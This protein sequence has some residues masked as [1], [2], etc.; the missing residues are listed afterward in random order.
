MVSLFL[1]NLFFTIL[2]PGTVAVLVPY[3]LLSGTGRT[4]LPANWTIWHVP[5]LVLGLIGLAIM[6]VCIW[7]FPVEGKGTISPVDPTR[8]LVTGGLYRYSR[9][10]MYVG[11]TLLLAGE[12]LF[13]QS[14]PMAVYAIIAF[15]AFHVFVLLHEEPR[16]KRVFGEEYDEYRA[17]VRQWL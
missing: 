7:R 8:R 3:L 15:A 2:Q 6:M 12:A 14:W 5:G 13:W 17:K 1:R 10:P 9:N 11:V 4:F 16:L